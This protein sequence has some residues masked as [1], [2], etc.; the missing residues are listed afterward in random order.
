MQARELKLAA[1]LLQEGAL[2]FEEG[3]L[4]QAPRAAAFEEY[5]R[6]LRAS[7]LFHLSLASK[8]LFHSNFLAWLCET[9]PT[10]VGPLFARF[11]NAPNAACEQLT[12]HREQRNTDLTI[13][14]PNGETLVVE[15]KVKSIA[16]ME[17]LQRYSGQ[18]RDR[19]RTS[20]LLLS[21]IRPPLM[22]PDEAMVWVDEM[23]WHFLSYS[24]LVGQLAPVAASIAAA[25]RYHGD[26]VGDYLG[27]VKNLVAIASH[28]ALDWDNEEVN[29][30]A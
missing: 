9:Y 29:F 27:F 19:K 23:P 8:E 4:V 3:R 12:V 26:L 28:V 17:Q 24:D 11:T 15:N 14:F 10:L 16:T 5:V 30:W 18:Q 25:N 20:F 22:P 1:K 13:E 6:S 7:P 21:L 2:R